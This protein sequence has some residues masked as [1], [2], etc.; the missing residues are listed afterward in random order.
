MSAG[1]LSLLRKKEQDQRE[2]QGGK[3]WKNVMTLTHRHTMVP[4]H[5][6]LQTYLAVSEP[7]IANL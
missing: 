5:P 3:N 1:D 6:T 2:R 7:Q 4:R